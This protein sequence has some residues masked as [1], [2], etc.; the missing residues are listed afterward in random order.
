M[1]FT[2]EFKSLLS[3]DIIY[4]S[5]RSDMTDSQRMEKVREVLM[6]MRMKELRNNQNLVFR[7]FDSEIKNLLGHDAVSTRASSRDAR[8]MSDSERLDRIREKL[9]PI[10]FYESKRSLSSMV[11]DKSD[12]ENDSDNESNGTS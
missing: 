3:T 5:D 6:R 8:V 12:S 4:N 11:Y 1:I 9:M 10:R 7:V 2:P